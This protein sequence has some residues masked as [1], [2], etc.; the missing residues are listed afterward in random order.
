MGHEDYARGAPTCCPV[1]ELRQYTLHPGHRDALIELFERE[2]L[3]PQEAVGMTVVGQFRD[4]D[5]PDRFIWIRG[6]QDMEARAAALAA[7]YEGPVWA[8]HREAANATMV[9]SDDVLLLRPTEDGAGFRLPDPGEAPVGTGSGDG[10]VVATVCHL[11]APADANLIAG[12][13]NLLRPVLTEHGGPVLA[14][15]V[16]EHAP[17]T[18]PRLPVR[19]GTQVLVWFAAFSDV[20]SYDRHRAAIAAS[21]AWRE[22]LDEVLAPRLAAEPI[23]LR[24]APTPR[25]RLQACD[26]L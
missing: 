17:N 6:F 2:L 20:A 3:E 13:V 23:S 1:V 5:D 8:S 24:L 4:R 25:S 14:S 22:A 26:L 7:F 21:A 16:T 12:F 18:Y 11:A 9:D 10:L 19:E 15:F